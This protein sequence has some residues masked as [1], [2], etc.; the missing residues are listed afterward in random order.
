MFENLTFSVLLLDLSLCDV[1]SKVLHGVRVILEFQKYE[2]TPDI[3]G[4]RFHVHPSYAL[5]RGENVTM[6]MA[7]TMSELY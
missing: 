3:S 1:R 4:T 7:V 6:V 2:N 5:A